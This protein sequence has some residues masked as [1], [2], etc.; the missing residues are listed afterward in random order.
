MASPVPTTISALRHGRASRGAPGGTTPVSG[1]VR[2]LR[3]V[4]GPIGDGFGAPREGGRTHTGIDFPVAYGTRIGAAGVG[5]V[6]FAG[7]NTGG[8][9][10]LV[11]V[12]HRLGYTTWYAHMSRIAVS[13]GQSVTGGSTLG[14]VGSTGHS[15]GPHLHFELRRNAVPINPVPYLLAAVAT[16]AS[17][18]SAS[19]SGGGG[20]P[21]NG[22]IEEQ[23]PSGG[24]NTGGGVAARECPIRE[25]LLRYGRAPLDACKAKNLTRAR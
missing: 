16:R 5:V 1:P 22:G 18:S 21:A 2:L 20:A 15:T 24:G 23:G 17:A 3:P 13:A 7:F 14:Y 6:E 19:G 25:P 4:G 8:Y 12:R 11:V 9:G 10:N